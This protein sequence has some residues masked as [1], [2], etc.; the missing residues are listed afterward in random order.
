V[1]GLIF[2]LLFG[3]GFG[4]RF[5]EGLVLGFTVGLVVGF[6][7]QLMD[8]ITRIQDAAT[9]PSQPFR[10]AVASK[11]AKPLAVGLA[12]GLAFG[13]GVGLPAGLTLGAVVVGLAVGLLTGL[14]AGIAALWIDPVLLRYALAVRALR[15][16][17]HL[18]PRAARF[19]DW[20]Y[21]AG[22]LRLAG[23]ATQFRHRDLQTHFT[24]SNRQPLGVG[25]RAGRW[26]SRRDRVS[27]KPI[28]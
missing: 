27:W 20:A 28:R 11:I 1:L 7:L 8:G 3:Q 19:L 15:R 4:E 6:T 13:L 10:R 2:G 21:T 18:P 17:R 24:N 14:L 12:G 16:T 25:R 26:V 9:C 22:L 23:I 5:G